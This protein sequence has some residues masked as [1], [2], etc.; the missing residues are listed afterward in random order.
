MASNALRRGRVSIPGQTY[1]IT[2]VTRHRRPLLVAHHI[3]KVVSDQ[4]NRLERQ[5]DGSWSAWVIMPDHF[6]G[7]LTLGASRDLSTVVKR[8]KARSARL[9]GRGPLWQSLFHDH[10]LRSHESIAD[11][12]RYVL[13]NPIRAG[14]VTHLADYPWWYCAWFQVGDDPQWL[15]ASG[16]DGPD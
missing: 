12:A 5:G 14:L 11:A 16:P 4:A 6:H 2:T 8:L 15:Y 3:A 1:L 9:A 7:L 13:T 10:A